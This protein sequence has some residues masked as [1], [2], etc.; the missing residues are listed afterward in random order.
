MI[1]LNAM[2][3]FAKLVEL[4]SF[5][6]VAKQRAI[7]VS[8]LSRKIRGLERDLGVR[9]LERSTRKLRITDLGREYYVYCQRV[10]EESDSGNRMI[11]NRQLEVSGLL[12][13]SVPPSLEK[14][15][16]VP[17]LA[18]FHARYPKVRIRIWVNQKKLDLIADGIDIALRVG[19]LHDSSL[20][21]RRLLVYRHVLVAAAGYLQR[22]G[23]P[24]HPSD[25]HQHRLIAFCH[26]YDDIV[27][28]FRRH[29]T[30]KKI[31]VEES[32]SMSDF[33]GMQLAAQAE[34]GITEVPS[35]ICGDALAR[36]D[37]VE[38]LPEWG[39]SPFNSSEVAIYAV[40]PSN[41]HLSQLVRVFKDYC[42]EYIESADFYI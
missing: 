20:V 4:Q 21:A 33:G 29:G 36:G 5:S 39:F 2:A 26:G 14:C 28:Y 1:D 24:Q 41:H 31:R 42:I 17:L 12:R 15:L 9:L 35:I 8:T 18:G 7:P 25:L 13:L 34:L 37:L 32:I 23:V 30:T 16:L 11:G 19:N 38:V 40:Y 10:A 27:W 6:K 22:E 3:L